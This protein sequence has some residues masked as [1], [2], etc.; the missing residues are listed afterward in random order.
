MVNWLDAHGW[1][2]RG[3]QPTAEHITIGKPGTTVGYVMGD[4]TNEDYLVI[5]T[6]HIGREQDLTP[7]CE[8]TAIPWGCIK[9]IKQLKVVK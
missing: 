2:I 7:S 3:H 6:E 4:L 9:E 5:K 1:D 8:G